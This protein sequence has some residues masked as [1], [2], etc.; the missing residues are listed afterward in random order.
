MPEI[1]ERACFNNAYRGPRGWRILRAVSDELFHKIDITNPHCCSQK[2]VNNAWRRQWSYTVDGLGHFWFCWEE[3]EDCGQEY[4]N[5]KDGEF[6]I[7]LK[8]MQDK[9]IEKIGAID[10]EKESS[11]DGLEDIYKGTTSTY[12]M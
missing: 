3:S 12:K 6:R 11:Y 10:D 4:L 8:E 5:K 7:A 2:A 1:R 9:W